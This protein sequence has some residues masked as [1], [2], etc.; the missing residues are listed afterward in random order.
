MIS[1]VNKNKLLLGVIDMSLELGILLYSCFKLSTGKSIIDNINKNSLKS[2]SL[3]K[4]YFYKKLS[5]DLFEI[6][7]SAK[8]S[9]KGFSIFLNLWN[10]I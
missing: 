5:Y 10:F 2:I 7:C 9:H 6:I 4:I 3:Y 8:S 1:F